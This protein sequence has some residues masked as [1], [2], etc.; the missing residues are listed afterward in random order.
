[1]RIKQG[2]SYL[3]VNKK[4]MEEFFKKAESNGFDLSDCF[5]KNNS[6]LV[7][8]FPFFANTD[9][10]RKVT[11]SERNQYDN[12]VSYK[13]SNKK[14]VKEL[15]DFLGWEENTWYETEKHHY[16]SMLFFNDFFKLPED[17][18]LKMKFSNGTFFLK[19]NKKTHQTSDIYNGLLELKNAIELENK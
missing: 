2:I 13:K 9:N 15:L 4:D 6:T 19:W 7:Y 11:L 12:I 18:L 1:M 17:Y 10:D 8:P 16:I 3:I 14:F 5:S